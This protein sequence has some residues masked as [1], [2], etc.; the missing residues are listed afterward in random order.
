MKVLQGPI[1][2][3]KRIWHHEGTQTCQM[4]LNI[5]LK[6]SFVEYAFLATIIL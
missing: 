4:A 5:S 6:T 1:T 2:H 3:G